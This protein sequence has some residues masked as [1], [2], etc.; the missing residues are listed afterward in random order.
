MKPTRTIV[1]SFNAAIEKI[2]YVLKTQ[3]EYEIAFYCCGGH[4][5]NCLAYT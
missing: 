1:D 2:V 3:E 4:Y 5:N